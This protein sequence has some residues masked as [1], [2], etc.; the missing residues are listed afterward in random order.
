MA[1]TKQSVLIVD[2]E[3]SNLML[4]NKVLSPDYTVFIAKSGQ[5]A[6]QRAI[7]KKPDLILLDIIM[8]GIDGYDVLMRLKESV[9]T[10]NIPVIIITGLT[11]SDDEEKGLFWG[12]VD[13]ITK[14]FKNVV[15]KARVKMHMKMI[16]Q[17]RLIETL[18]SVD[19][20][21]EMPS[22]R[23]FRERAEFMVKDAVRDKKPVSVIDIDVD[24]FREYNG[25]FGH[26][27]GDECIKELA[28]LVRSSLRPTDFGARLGGD[29]FGV[30]LAGTAA[31]D[32]AKVAETLR[33]AIESY[34]VAPHDDGGGETSE[35]MLTS[36]TATLGVVTVTPDEATD[37]DALIK[38][39]K[40]LTRAAKEGGG[41]CV[42]TKTI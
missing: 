1:E 16:E 36:V 27:Q 15:V 26:L 9:S 33:A 29:C 28:N 35:K 10:K 38:E 5:E 7:D 13:Y 3:T 25:V 23:M 34:K 41:N 8:P 4:L 11:S 32:A 39:V 2:D 14:P 18:N 30:L 17:E 12:A 6:L 22:A 19:G 42:A 37:A 40:E 20:L 31:E 21:T 24:N